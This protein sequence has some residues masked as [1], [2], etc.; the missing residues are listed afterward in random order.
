MNSL[1][2]TLKDSQYLSPI[3]FPN[4]I[5]PAKQANLP[6]LHYGIHFLE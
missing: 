4:Q 1:R 2:T 5:I 3:R 6:V